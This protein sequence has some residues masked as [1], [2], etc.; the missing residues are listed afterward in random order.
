MTA[1]DTDAFWHWW[2]INWH[3]HIFLWSL[4]HCHGPSVKCHMIQ[5]LFEQ[6]CD[7][8]SKHIVAETKWLPFPDDIFKCLFLNENIWISIKI[9]LNFVPNGPINNISASVQIMA[10][11][12]PGDKPLSE[13]MMVYLLTHICVTRPQWVKRK[14]L[15]IGAKSTYFRM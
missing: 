7:S 3:Q 13:P 10:W 11:C 4:T 6:V 8:N 15:S 1:N 5:W 2:R 12:R 14:M 9:S